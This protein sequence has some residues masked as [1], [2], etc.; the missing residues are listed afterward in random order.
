MTGNSIHLRSRRT[1]WHGF[2]ELRGS[3]RGRGIQECRGMTLEDVLVGMTTLWPLTVKDRDAQPRSS[4]RLRVFA[5]RRPETLRLR[6]PARRSA[7]RAFVTA[8]ASYHD[9]PAHAARRGVLLV[10]DRRRRIRG[11]RRRWFRS[12]RGRPRL[13]SRLSLWTF[14]SA[15]LPFALPCCSPPRGIALRSRGTWSPASG[16]C[17]RRSTSRSECPGCASCQTARSARG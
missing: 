15:T 4:L 16:R 3:D 8:A 11:R 13:G 9:R 7:V 5:V 10:L 2:S 14:D 1:L 6:A 12:C 17:S